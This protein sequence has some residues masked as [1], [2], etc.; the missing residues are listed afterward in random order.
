MNHNWEVFKIFKEGHPYQGEYYLWRCSNCGYS[1][2][3]KPGD[4]PS[5]IVPENCDERVVRSILHD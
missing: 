2:R 5:E 3:N 1:S 4:H